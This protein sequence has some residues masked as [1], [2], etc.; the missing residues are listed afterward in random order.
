MMKYYYNIAILPDP[1]CPCLC[2]AVLVLL[3]LGKL[4]RKG[5]LY[6]ALTVCLVLR[7]KLETNQVL[8]RVHF[9]CLNKNILVTE[10]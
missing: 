4:C 7:E 10:E 5:G 6:A 1:R 8:W 2:V 9:I 3:V